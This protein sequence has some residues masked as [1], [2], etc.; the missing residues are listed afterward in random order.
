MGAQVI[1]KIEVLWA[2]FQFFR[3]YTEPCALFFEN[4]AV[5][6]RSPA[7]QRIRQDVE[8]G[9]DPLRFP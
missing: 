2:Q 6:L 7:R 1:L 3:G 5:G 8:M 4:V 9:G